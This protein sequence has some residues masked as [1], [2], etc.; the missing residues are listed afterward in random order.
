MLQSSSDCLEMQSDKNRGDCE[1]CK[2]KEK[3]L[4]FLQLLLHV[5]SDYRIK[6][7]L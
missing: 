3:I 1:V 7:E 2:Q 5:L 4:Q 6:K